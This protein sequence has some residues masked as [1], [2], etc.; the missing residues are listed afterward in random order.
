MY[1]SH[2]SSY[3]HSPE[4]SKRR[5]IRRTYSSLSTTMPVR[6]AVLTQVKAL[7]DTYKETCLHSADMD[8]E[9]PFTP[10]EKNK[11]ECGVRAEPDIEVPHGSAGFYLWEMVEKGLAIEEEEKK[12]ASMRSRMGTVLPEA[13]ESGRSRDLAAKKAGFKSFNSYFSAKNVYLNAHKAILDLVEKGVLRLTPASSVAKLPYQKQ[14]LMAQLISSLMERGGMSSSMIGYLIYNSDLGDEAFLIRLR[15]RIYN[16]TI[17]TRYDIRTLI[18]SCAGTGVDDPLQSE[19]DDTTET[20]EVGD[21]DGFVVQLEAVR[22][23]LCELLVTQSEIKDMP[24]NE[25][26]DADMF[27]RHIEK[28]S[29]NIR[30][31]LRIHSSLFSDSFKDLVCR[32]L[33][34][35]KESVQFFAHELPRKRDLLN[36]SLCDE[37]NRTF[38][39]AL[40][41]LHSTA[42][43]P[44]LPPCG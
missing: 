27:L 5:I 13:T 32:Y 44:D 37:L 2:D 22:T 38:H 15:D 41:L 11:A 30:S 43:K 20:A 9:P 31:H 18:E 12:R 25:A 28:I 42:A 34:S 26:D 24:D 39:N 21:G 17:T 8:E 14:Y 3:S 4:G 23:M 16:T 35:F 36:E 19:H 40:S 6:F 33:S 10:A 29:G 1:S 7:N